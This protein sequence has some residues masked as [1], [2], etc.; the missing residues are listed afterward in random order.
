[1][2]VSAFDPSAVASEGKRK[3]VQAKLVAKT[4]ELAST[5]SKLAGA[6]DAAITGG[7]KRSGGHSDPYQSA[8]QSTTKRARTAAQGTS[9]RGVRQAIPTP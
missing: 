2:G 5:Q 8:S 1:M 4:A 6:L 7:P 3:T 9:P